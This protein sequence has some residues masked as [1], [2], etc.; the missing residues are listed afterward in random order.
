VSPW[1][2]TRGDF[3]IAMIKQSLMRAHPYKTICFIWAA[4][5]SQQL[6]LLVCGQPKSLSINYDFVAIQEELKYL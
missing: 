2:G 5:Y 3:L 6:K 1:N 4:R